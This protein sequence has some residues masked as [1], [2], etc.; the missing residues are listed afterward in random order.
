MSDGLYSD[1]EHEII[2]WDIDDDKT[3]GHLTRRLLNIVKG[4]VYDI[5]YSENSGLSHEQRL[6]E[7]KKLFDQHRKQLSLSIVSDNSIIIP[8]PKLKFEGLDNIS[9]VGEKDIPLSELLELHL[10]LENYLKSR[11]EVIINESGLIVGF[12]NYY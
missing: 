6:D 10:K 9:I 11:P 1:I 3:A 5:I 7:I 12:K 4:S 8:K 2:V